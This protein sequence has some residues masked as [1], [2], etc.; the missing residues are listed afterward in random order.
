METSRRGAGSAGRS[1]IPVRSLCSARQAP[2]SDCER[3]PL[4]LERSYR[5]CF[6]QRPQ[7]ASG[8]SFWRHAAQVRAAQM[9]ETIQHPTT[10]SEAA[11]GM[12]DAALRA[13]AWAGEPLL[14]Q[15]ED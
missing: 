8:R 10:V 13:E 7:G 5:L 3:L 9:Q 11:D 15:D 6:R 2:G 1:R 12:I 14:R 4:V